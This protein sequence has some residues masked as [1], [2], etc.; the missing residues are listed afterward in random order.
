MLKNG[1]GRT[2]GVVAN[3]AKYLIVASLGVAGVAVLADAT[4]AS[5]A[6]VTAHVANDTPAERLAQKIAG[7]TWNS[8]IEIPGSAALNT[9]GNAGILAISCTSTG[10]CGAGGNYVDGSGNLQAFVVNEVGG[11]WG[12]SI[13]VPGTAAL[14]AG[15]AAS[16]N[17]ISCTSNG[18]CAAVGSFTDSAGDVQG[19]F[20]NEAANTWGTASEAVD[21]AAIG[22]VNAAGLVSVSC[23]TDVNCSAV[24]LDVITGGIPVGYAISDTNGT[25]GDVTDINLTS[26][27]G[28]GGTGLTAVS[29]VSPGNCGAEGIGVYQDA[30]VHGGA[31][32]I[33]FEV[34]ESNGTWG[35]PSTFPGLSTLNVGLVA[36]A[37]AISCTAPGDCSTGGQYTDGLAN[38][39]AFVADESN[40]TWGDAIEVP[41]SSTL[42]VGAAVVDSISCNSPG[43]CGA[44]GLYTTSTLSEAFVASETNGSW[45]SATEIPGSQALF[46]GGAAVETNPISCSSAGN[47][48]T[49]GAYIDTLGNYQAYVAIEKGGTWGDSIELPGSS[50]LNTAGGA[51]V[52][53][54]SCSEDSGCGAG[55]YY[56][57]GTQTFQALVTDMSPLFAAQAPISLTSTHGKVGT[58]LTLT[59]S[60]GSGAGAV[61]FTVTNGSAKGCAVT[62]KVLT[63]TSGGTCVVT[64]TKANDGTYLAT[65]S[66][67]TPV[68]MVLPARPRPLTVTFTGTSSAL[69]GAARKELTALSRE[70]ISGASITITGYAKGNPNLAFS[71]AVAAEGIFAKRPIVHI[72]LLRNSSVA[73]NE[74]TVVVTK[75]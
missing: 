6:S 28:P 55:G 37:D 9:G 51:Q 56:A 61:T 23:S 26:T 20:V 73:K 52:T 7:G 59:T 18:D 54:I 11:T 12:T 16:V 44:S 63:A 22:S 38:S 68:A 30:S 19:F 72:K 1:S 69:S 40:G 43:N 58:A 4:P 24:G 71:R 33:P 14:N 39:Q 42:N 31:A 10:N 67:A 65:S 49:G 8:A 2:R 34:N 13:E 46:F 57:T 74:V 17:S 29:C 41:G 60:G 50:T 70:L 45:G 47:C 75:Q 32:Y 3:F 35:S 36:T 48:S 66:A 25:W 64:A 21:P 27:L 15:G 53:A 5:A 62:N